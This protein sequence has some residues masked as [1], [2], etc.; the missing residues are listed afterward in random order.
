M[1]PFLSAPRFPVGL[2]GVTPE[3][4]DTARLLDAVRQAASGGMRALQL[5]RKLASPAHRLA[6]ARACA[7]L[8]RELGVVF[9]INDDSVLAREVGADGVHLGR[10]DG[11]PALVRRTAGTDLLIGASCYDDAALAARMVVADVDYVAFGAV[12]PSS[13]KPDA[14]R[15]PLAL[16]TQVRASLQSLAPRRPAVVAIGGITPENAGAVVQAGADAV[17]VITGLFEATDIAAAARR[18]QAH[19]SSLSD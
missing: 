10:E 18:C 15:A 2:Y 3:W 9:L 16:L 14:V 12:Y 19:F 5:R 17:A 6:Q 7:D 11:D 4:D 1:N 8:C 13:V